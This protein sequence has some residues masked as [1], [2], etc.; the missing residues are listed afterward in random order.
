MEEYY[1]QEQSLKSKLQSVIN[2]VHSE[3]VSVATIMDLIGREGLLLLCIFLTL[4][5]MVPV[6]I[7]GVHGLRFVHHPHRCGPHDQPASLD[8]RTTFKEGI[9]L[10][11][12]AVRS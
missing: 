5:F 2:R 8:S 4:P 10:V 9:S 12:A 1:E 11:K 3:T 7:P 6:S